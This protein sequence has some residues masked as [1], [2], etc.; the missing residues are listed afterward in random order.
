V[1]SK[2]SAKED[3]AAKARR[4]AERRRVFFMVVFLIGFILTIITISNGRAM[5][6]WW[7]CILFRA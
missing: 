5:P 2:A 3:D 6:L 4:R 1:N 7:V